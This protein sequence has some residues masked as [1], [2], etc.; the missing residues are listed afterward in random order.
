MAASCP[1]QAGWVQRRPAQPLALAMLL[2][3]GFVPGAGGC[4]RIRAGGFLDLMRPEVSVRGPA[5]PG[6]VQGS[7]V[8]GW[9]AVLVAVVSSAARGPRR[10]GERAGQGYLAVQP[11]QAEQPPGLGPGADHMQAAAV[12]G[13]PLAAPARTPSPAAS[14]KLPGPGRRPAAGRL[15][16]ARIAARAAGSRWRCRSPRRQ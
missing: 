6:S 12:R 11:G 7:P 3:P 1:L 10:L 4:G 2:E 15:R 9:P 13:G 16:L 5:R 8:L 14:M